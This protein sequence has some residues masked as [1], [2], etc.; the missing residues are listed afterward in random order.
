MIRLALAVGILVLGVMGRL[1]AQEDVR[2]IEPVLIDVQPGERGVPEPAKLAIY[3]PK[4]MTAADAGQ[5]IQGLMGGA[6]SVQVEPTGNSLLMR[7]GESQ[8][9]EVRTVLEALDQPPKQI[10]FEVLFVDLPATADEAQPQNGQADSEAAW[11]SRLKGP[12]SKI[13][14]KLSTL[15]LTATENQNAMVQFG[16]Q[17]PVATGFQQQGFGRGAPAE[18]SPMIRNTATGT[19]VQCTARVL[20]EGT[21]MA[22]FEIERSRLAPESGAVLEESDDRG[23]LK[24]PGQ[25]TTTCKTTIKLKPGQPRIISGLKSPQGTGSTLNLIVIT[26][27][28]ISDK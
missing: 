22:E 21:I 6:V 27:E 17:T 25:L 7:A 8:L 3:K 19:I 9:K 18:R 24:T 11:L 15:R 20:E 5:L 23:M 28:L 4:H 10:A 14:G 12:E 1:L 2:E 13:T 16:E 26:A